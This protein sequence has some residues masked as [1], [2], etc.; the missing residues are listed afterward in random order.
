LDNLSA[1]LDGTGPALL[2]STDPRVL[3]VLRP[4]EPL[5]HDNVAL[6]VPTSGS[7]GK[8]KGALLTAANV[9]ASAEASAQH[10]GGDGQWLLAIPATHIGGL[11]VLIRS[12]LAGTVPVLLEG[13]TTVSSFE[14]ATAQLTASKRFVSIVPTQLRR[15]VDSPALL[16]YDAVLLGGAAAPPTLLARARKAGVRVVTTYGMSETSGGCVYDGVGLAG[17]TFALDDRT[18]RIRLSGPVVGRGYR[19]R[20]DLTA[21]SFDKHSF[22]TADVGELDDAGRL[23]VLG[24]ADHVI[25]TGGEK[26]APASVEDVLGEHPAVAELAVV[27]ISDA[28]WGHRVV[29]CVVLRPGQTLTLEQAREHVAA[30]LPRAAAPRELRVLDALP[31]LGSGKIDRMRLAR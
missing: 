21:T 17:V 19:L 1:A 13:P 7:T 10:L 16:A 26:V 11:Q 22:L 24:R 23:V 15:L 2:P 3:D 31:L 27:G 9:R 14:A 30:R 6:V 18:H 25:V 20:P 12:L 29:A 5:E 4:D 8:P 28:E